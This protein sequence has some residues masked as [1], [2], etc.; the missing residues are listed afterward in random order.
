[1]NR[2]G[3]LVYL[4][5]RLKIAIVC[6]RLV[7]LAFVGRVC[8]TNLRTRFIDTAPVILLKMFASRMDQQIPSPALYE[9][10]GALM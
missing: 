9:N 3:K 10:R 5:R 8:A 4:F 7:E 6:E 1:M 2:V